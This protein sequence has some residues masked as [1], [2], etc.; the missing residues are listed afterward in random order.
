MP[1]IENIAKTALG[2]VLVSLLLLLFANQFQT[3][4]RNQVPSDTVYTTKEVYVHL[5]PQYIEVP[6]PTKVVKIPGRDSIRTETLFVE[7]DRLREEARAT[8]AERIFSY[9]TIVRP[10]MDT[11]SARFYEVAR[12]AE[13]RINY[14]PRVS[15]IEEM[16]ISPK[17]INRF[18]FGIGVGATYSDGFK[19]YPVIGVHYKLLEF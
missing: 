13:I 3:C 17:E 6:G 1:S 18:V 9:D 7:I 16:R 5:P 11:V 14:A 4:N 19:A 8:G 10:Q 2:L 12:T 15:K